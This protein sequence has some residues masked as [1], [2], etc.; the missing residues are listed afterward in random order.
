MDPDRRVI[1]SRT[2]MARHI[3][4]LLCP[5]CSKRIEIDVRSGKTRAVKFEESSK[6]KDLT[7][8][9]EEQ[10]REGERLGDLF[11]EARED[12]INQADRLGELFD[13]ASEDARQDPDR[14]KKPPN[15][16]DLE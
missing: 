12:H 3:F 10:K 4:Q 7:G 13:K 1:G 2:S 6:G 16:F 15:P 9:V 5:C 11:A 8:L 14:G